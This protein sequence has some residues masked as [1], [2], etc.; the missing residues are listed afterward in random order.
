MEIAIQVAK[1]LAKAHQKGII[2]RDIKPAN[3]MITEDG[4][5]K[6]VD[7][8]LA[9]LASKSELTRPEITMGTLSYISPEQIQ[10]KKINQRT[11]I[12]SFGVMLYEM[13]TGELP[14]KGE[15]DQAVIY[16]ILNEA[17]DPFNITIS[18]QLQRIIYKALEK[19]LENRYK[20]MEEVIND[21]ETVEKE[22]TDSVVAKP[23][24]SIAVL[25]F[26]NMSND[27]SQE[28]FCDGMAEEIINSLTHVQ[29][30]RVVARTSSF[31][32]K[33]KQ[34]EI[35]DIGRK[36]NVEMILE[37]SV[38][39]SVSRLRITAQLINVADG[40]HIWS[41]KFD[42]T[43]EDVFTIQDEISLSIIDKLKLSLL[44]EEKTKLTKRYTK[45][46][47]AYHLL[48]KGRYFAVKMTKED[49]LK[50]L[51]YY[52]KA[53]Q[54]DPYYSLAYS[55]LAECYGFLGLYY[56]IPVYKLIGEAR[57]A[58][59]KAIET[60]PSLSEAHSAL[61]FIK[62]FL[63]WDFI[64]LEKEFKT[65]LKLNPNSE[66]AQNGYAGYLL[67]IGKIDEA[68]E[69]QKISLD[70][71]P[72]SLVASTHL[73]MYLLRQKQYKEARKEL[74]KSLELNS[75]H[76]YAL[77]LIGMSYLLES[78]YEKGIEEIERAL[79]YSNNFPPILSALGWAYANFG[80]KGKAQKVIKE[81]KLKT[82]KEYI[83]PYLFAKIYSE[84]N[85]IDEAFKYLDEAYNQ[86]D[87]AL[88]HILTDEAIDNLRT[89]PR[90]I[91]LIK[92]MDLYKYY[93]QDA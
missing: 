20:T 82:K 77:W 47:K 46:I 61:G 14:F 54:L 34:V 85:K 23:R 58:A 75:H 88:I 53:I 10:G 92:K 32:F 17:P 43:I 27:E 7:F 13:L 89:D 71:N 60:D 29:G 40:F 62:G 12:W 36:L 44:E 76:P 9:R 38:R 22:G 33:G 15:I 49:L 8:G 31:S 45:N 35:R 28:Y 48:L 25:P 6:I 11:D 24:Q 4:V 1:G 42:R 86:H 26:K 56:F 57:E 72:L 16:S 41:D 87:I 90:Y 64:S 50:S 68:V 84:L 73:G 65:A 78:N 81:L 69:A 83:S 52:Q 2:H 19:N 74:E 37:G 59:R 18:Q 66:Q 67:V 30:L 63:E 55:G 3:I 5:A 70:L 80:E 21:L 93:K 51:E 39:K 91:E 79:T